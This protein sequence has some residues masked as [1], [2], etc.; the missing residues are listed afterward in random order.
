MVKLQDILLHNTSRCPQ[1]GEGERICKFVKLLK[2]RNTLFLQALHNSCLTYIKRTK[3]LKSEYIGYG[4]QPASTQEAHLLK[5]KPPC[6][7]QFLKG[8]V[9][10]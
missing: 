4:K 5:L 9:P 7:G 1:I 2:S 3:A 6:L 8:R 10:V